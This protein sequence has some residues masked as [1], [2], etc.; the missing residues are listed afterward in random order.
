MY[1]KCLI[2]QEKTMKNS[3][4]KLPED[5]CAFILTH[6][7]PNK[8]ATYRTL[9]GNGYTGKIYLVCDDEDEALPQYKEKFGDEVLVFSK[10]KIGESFDLADTFHSK[11]GVIV[12]ARNACFDLAKKVGCNHFVQL[13]D[14]YDQFRLQLKGGNDIL[15]RRK[16]NLDLM[17]GAF[18]N[19]Y[20]SVP[21]ISAAFV[22]GG[23]L[24]GGACTNMLRKGYKLKRKAMNSF[25]CSLDRP[26]TFV[27]RINEDVNT[28]TTLGMRGEVFLTIPFFYLNQATTQSNSGG[29]TETYLDGGT[30]LKS[31]YSVMMQPSCV[32]IE[33]MKSTHKRI[34]HKV[35][36]K[37][38]TPMILHER[39]RK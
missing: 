12:F 21:I 5:F 18:F 23:D 1:L 38:C 28:Y 32:R 19:F 37:N 16:V 29:M 33:M 10:D 31:F 27:G 39:F 4:Y 35:L 13:D 22:Q 20:R 36:W 11:K 17:F 3:K 30:Y 14:D 26:F 24:L 34:H 9:R 15:L 7:R 8:V 6:G 25:F 2:L